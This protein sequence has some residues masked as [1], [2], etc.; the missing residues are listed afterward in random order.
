[1][2][3]GSGLYYTLSQMLRFWCHTQPGLVYNKDLTPSLRLG[4]VGA[5][6]AAARDGA[7]G[8]EPRPYEAGGS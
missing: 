6:L 7:G 1:M 2:K 4:V 3:M 5:A 8:G